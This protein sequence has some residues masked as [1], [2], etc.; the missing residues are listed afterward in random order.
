MSDFLR[1]QR[2]ELA[3]FWQEGLA[4]EVRRVSIA[5]AVLVI[6]FY[7]ACM[8]LS[9]VREALVGQVLGVLDSLEVIQ[10][11]G[12]LSATLLFASNLNAC[13]FMMLY[14]LVPFIR[15]PALTLGLNAM[16]LGALASWYSAQGFS[17]LVYLAFLFPHG[18]FELPAM[19]LSLAVGLYV[20]KQVTR[21][22]RGDAEALPLGG[23]CLLISRTVLLAVTPLLVVAAFLEAYV[24]PLFA[25][26]FF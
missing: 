17:L 18:I 4:W 6:L 10:E 22:F 15:L 25:S 9:P 24:T 8:L 20:C 7:G 1:R 12:S 2:E 21:R 26:L 11:D 19:A 5:F 23:C 16:M 13:I 3:R 14:G